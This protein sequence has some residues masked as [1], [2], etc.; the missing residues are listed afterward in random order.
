MRKPR[1]DLNLLKSG[2]V[3]PVGPLPNPFYVKWTFVTEVMGVF[4][5]CGGLVVRGA[6]SK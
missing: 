1:Y 4:F 2:R 6:A 5:V 3:A